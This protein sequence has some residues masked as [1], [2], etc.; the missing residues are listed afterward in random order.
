MFQGNKCRCKASF[1]WV[2]SAGKCVKMETAAVVV[3]GTSPA[4]PQ[5]T[6]VE[7]KV[8]DVPV[9][10][11]KP[12][13]R[14]SLPKEI[15]DTAQDVGETV[16]KVTLKTG[17]TI[18]QTIHT[19]LSPVIATLA[20]G[21]TRLTGAAARKF[22]NMDRDHLERYVQ[23]ILANFLLYHDT[24]TT[25]SC[26]QGSGPLN[27]IGT[28]PDYGRCYYDL[29]QLLTP[30]QPLWKG[31]VYSGGNG[32]TDHHAT[33]FDITLAVKVDQIR[34]L[35]AL[36][37]QKNQCYGDFMTSGGFCDLELAPDEHHP[38]KITGIELDVNCEG[39]CYAQ[40][41][42]TALLT[43]KTDLVVGDEVYIEKKTTK[44]VNGYLGWLWGPS[45][46]EVAAVMRKRRLSGCSSPEARGKI[47]KNI[48]VC[49]NRKKAGNKTCEKE[50]RHC[51]EASDNKEH[52]ACWP[53]E[54]LIAADDCV[55]TVKAWAARLLGGRNASA[56]GKKKWDGKRWRDERGRFAT[57]PDE[58]ADPS[59]IEAN[60]VTARP[61]IYRKFD[62]V[63]TDVKI[64]AR[65][66]IH[67]TRSLQEVVNEEPDHRKKS[68][69][70]AAFQKFTSNANLLAKVLKHP[71]EWALSDRQLV[72]QHSLNTREKKAPNGDVIGY[73]L[74]TCS[75]PVWVE[76]TQ[77]YDLPY[78]KCFKIDIAD[79]Q[80]LA[81][82]AD[83]VRIEET[84]AWQ[85]TPTGVYAIWRGLMSI[86]K[87]FFAALLG[88]ENIGL[89]LAAC[90]KI[91][92]MMFVRD[93]VQLSAN[94]R[95]C[96][97]KW[98]E[99]WWTGSYDGIEKAY[100]VGLK[101]EAKGLEDVED[102]Q[103]SGVNAAF[104]FEMVELFPVWNRAKKRNDME[105]GIRGGYNL[106]FCR[107]V[108]SIG[109]AERKSG[110]KIGQVLC[111][112]NAPV[113]ENTQM[114]RPNL[115]PENARFLVEHVSASEAAPKLVIQAGT[116]S[117]D[118][119]SEGRTA[120]SDH[121]VD[122]YG[123][124]CGS[125]S[126]EE[127]MENLPD[128]VAAEAGHTSESTVV[129][130]KNRATGQYCSLKKL[131]YKTFGGAWSKSRVMLTC[132]HAKPRDLKLEGNIDP[133]TPSRFW[134]L[135]LIMTFSAIFAGAGWMKGQWAM[136]F[137]GAG[138]LYFWACVA[139]GAMIGALIAEGIAIRGFHLDGSM[140]RYL[141]KTKC[142]GIGQ[143][144]LWCVES[145][146]VFEFPRP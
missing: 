92:R 3:G 136:L 143:Y 29:S 7:M 43:R 128:Q 132:D 61:I 41:H 60:Q 86:P 99:P 62:A 71:R 31:S 8:Q 50:I 19:A 49:S 6:Q 68:G 65:V 133:L 46:T 131:K 24:G 130:L 2:P 123:D 56:S 139:S 47:V 34:G 75:N 4:K 38:L 127:S 98:H 110:A 13:S 70:A 66:Y 18:M 88:Y 36:Q 57:K 95:Y 94:G 144:I 51:I 107:V 124:N 142:Q 100:A 141:M 27:F 74:I 16:E 17:Q 44:M 102:D 112:L 89:V 5:A 55:G 53:K 33:K 140:I 146:L 59:S 28:T 106:Q 145:A 25:T 115:L 83:Y 111:D 117:R 58:N 101:C 11:L 76:D 79:L 125:Q 52:L 77:S 113:E 23:W 26:D 73:E 78:E 82:T 120:G 20:S 121:D 81:T 135:L 114:V 9:E 1:C 122:C 45:E 37:V 72:E 138:V 48:R 32:R 84:A 134:E 67:R 21:A 104:D 96:K 85:D 108:M 129:R 103:G 42:A 118:F 91:I 69:L 137:G 54:M 35:E 64:R 105:I 30:D 14:K 22:M 12:A 97:D 15:R 87:A 10:V 119:Q 63:F 126:S 90:E 80:L 116:S 93:V 109:S 39:D 40:Q